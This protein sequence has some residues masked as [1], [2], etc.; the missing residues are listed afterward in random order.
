MLP[1][2]APLRP[3]GDEAGGAA[4]LHFHSLAVH[5]TGSLAALEEDTASK[6]AG[7]RSTRRGQEFL[8]F[9]PALG[10]SPSPQPSPIK[11]EGV[12]LLL[13]SVSA[14]VSAPSFP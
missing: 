14:V 6:P 13:P 12:H 3:E 5:G 9:V 1:P 7:T 11:G 2:D 8:A 4:D 10:I